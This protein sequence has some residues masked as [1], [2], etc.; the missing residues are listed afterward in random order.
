MR[1]SRDKLLLPLILLPS[2]SPSFRLL[3]DALFWLP[4]SAK[5]K[6]KAL[7]PRMI[8]L[9]YAA[10]CLLAQS[11]LSSSFNNLYELGRVFPLVLTSICLSEI[12]NKEKIPTLFRHLLIIN[13][14][15][16]MANYTFSAELLAKFGFNDAPFYELYG[17]N[18]GVFAFL[19]TAGLLS[20]INL[21]FLMSSNE[22]WPFRL[23]WF[24]L[25]IAGLAISGSKTFMLTGML[26]IASFLMLQAPAGLKRPK[27]I[28]GFFAFSTI[29]AGA[30]YAVL[31][32]LKFQVFYQVTR[33]GVFIVTGSLSSVTAR[34]K[35]IEMY[36]D[37][38]NQ[39]SL[40][41]L[42]GTPKELLVHANGT[43]DNDYLFFFV[44]LG[45]PL[46]VLTVMLILSYVLKFIKVRFFFVAITILLLMVAAAAIPILSD[47][48]SSI[49]V[50][51][52]G[53]Y[54]SLL[55]NEKRKKSIHV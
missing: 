23:F 40:F 19:G 37:V 8:L 51:L 38:Q 29:I 52:L 6:L 25:V 20:F 41:Y 31:S 2:A 11:L 18:S 21:Y 43:F 12:R 47:I 55:A 27:K 39:N 15:V 45:V 5:T 7:S 48:Q 22:K 53:Y 32:K 4:F 49:L 14:L 35:K 30:V 10:M 33:L 44:R 26:L 54:F 42:I 1:F 9:L 13:L 36:L 17:R 50:V 24:F 3:I 16:S 34:F 28:L 46:T